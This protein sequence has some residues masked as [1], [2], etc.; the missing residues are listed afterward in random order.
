MEMGQRSISLPFFMGVPMDLNF[1]RLIFT[2]RL[3]RNKE[4]RFVLFGIKPFF[5]EAFLQSAGCPGNDGLP[6]EPCQCPYH[7]TFS[8]FLSTD[9]AA[10][11][12]YQ[13]PSLPF[14]FQIPVLPPLPNRDRSLEL[15]LV[16]TGNAINYLT[17]YLKAVTLMFRN[18]RFCSL[19]SVSL[20]KIESSDYGG[21]R[22][23]LM[24][25]GVS[26]YRGNLA[27]LSLTGVRDSEVLPPDSVTITIITPMKLLVMGKPLR[28]V[29]FSPFIRSLFRRV[30]SLTYY[31]GGSESEFDYKWLADRSKQVS[32]S[33][34]T[35][36][37]EEWGG[38]W[39]GLTGRATFA[40]DLT[41]FH[42]FLLAGEYL[43]LGKGAT[44]GL[45]RYILERADQSL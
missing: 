25:G 28:E 44:F 29:S 36:H 41:E 16:L 12:R 17:V 35:L 39:S 22:S 23:L 4:D 21:T 34:S 8:Q 13:K 15:E 38:K 6:S 9:P 27:P 1:V 20:E 43:H 7:Q 11:K 19:L 40:G 18:P 31:S 14:V 24:E 33:A 32:C 5:E 45:G 10:V 30:S 3:E 2:L 37:W 26:G 42:P